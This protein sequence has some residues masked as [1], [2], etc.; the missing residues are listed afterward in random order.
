MAQVKNIL[1][2][3]QNVKGQGKTSWTEREFE[4][5]LVKYSRANYRRSLNSQ[6]R[7]LD[8]ESTGPLVQ[9]QF[10]VQ[11]WKGVDG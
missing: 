5:Y 9:S 4:Q 6:E 3:L 8:R 2:Y 7:K 11:Q 1:K 10:W